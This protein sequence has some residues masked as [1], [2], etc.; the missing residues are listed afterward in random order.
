MRQSRASMMR[1]AQEQNVQE[2]GRQARKGEAPLSLKSW[3][4]KHSMWVGASHTHPHAHGH[5]RWLTSAFL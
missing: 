1:T 2:G 3:V 5:I 4:S